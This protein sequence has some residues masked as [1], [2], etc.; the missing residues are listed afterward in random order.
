MTRA[1]ALLALAVTLSVGWTQQEKVTSSVID[2]TR[3]LRDLQALSAD[4]MEGRQV[5]T[6][7]GAKARAYVI[8]RFIDSGLTPFRE[9]FRTAVHVHGPRR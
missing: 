5:G 2:A 4:D 1:L 3:L 6:P 8:R 7:G 9:E